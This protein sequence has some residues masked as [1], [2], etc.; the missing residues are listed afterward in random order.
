VSIKMN[1]A[2]SILRMLHGKN[3]CWRPG[4]AEVLRALFEGH[5]VVGCFPR[6]V[7]RVT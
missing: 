2:A 1:F 6:Q 7:V 4:Q 5:D 3:A